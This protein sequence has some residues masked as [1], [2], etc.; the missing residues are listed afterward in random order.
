MISLMQS[1]TDYYTVLHLKPGSSIEEIRRQYR[2]L[3]KVYHPDRNPGE[4][5]WCAE[6]LTA[7]NKAY[8][9]LSNPQRKAAYDKS[10]GQQQAAESAAPRQ[11]PTQAQARPTAARTQTSSRL[12]SLS[13]VRTQEQSQTSLPTRKQIA[14]AVLGVGGVGLA[15]ALLSMTLFAYFHPPQ[16]RHAYLPTATLY[17]RPHP[18]A[19]SALGHET[20]RQHGRSK[21]H[22]RR[23]VDRKAATLTKLGIRVPAN[24]FSKQELHDMAVRLENYDKSH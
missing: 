18:G 15:G 17:E 1:E 19:D 9:Y 20:W 23:N 4:E 11:A 14:I 3:A 7:V 2:R 8:E 22:T 16:S 5:D 21:L 6:Q 12:N 13:K 10:F 24:E